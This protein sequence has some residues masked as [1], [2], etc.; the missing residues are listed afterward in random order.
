MNPKDRAGSQKPGTD[1]LPLAVLYE[2]SLAFVE[3]ALK[4]G[5]WNWRKEKVTESIYI[6]AAKRHL[7]QHL[8]GETIDPDSGLPHIT[9]AIAGL[10]ILRDAQVHDCSIDD[11]TVEH[12]LNFK[13]LTD[14]LAVLNAKYPPKPEPEKEAAL[15]SQEKQLDEVFAGYLPVTLVPV[16]PDHEKRIAA[17]DKARRSKHDLKLTGDSVG[18]EYAL[19]S[20]Q[21]VR[22][23]C[24]DSY[25][26]VFIASNNESYRPN[27]VDL[28][29]GPESLNNISHQ[30]TGVTLTKS[31]VGKTAELT[32]GYR[33][34]IT[35]HPDTD[36]LY[37][38]GSRSFS[39]GG[40][41]IS[42]VECYVVKV[43][44]T[45]PEDDDHEYDDL[46]CEDF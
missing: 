37:K 23:E 43:L 6:T 29:G 38:V 46:D 33:G 3:G 2:V 13:D 18:R 5:P 1:R 24:Y 22:I 25:D 17:L 28:F 45:P 36:R 7:D 34:P 19:Q 10:L 15:K 11:R 44:S 8:S 31:D 41:C 4:Y 12:K 30:V 9:K 39:I 14:R 42:G 40:A 16:S 35:A 26:N 21:V 20:G 32:N 27:G